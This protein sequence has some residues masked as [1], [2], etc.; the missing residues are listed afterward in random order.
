MF[1]TLVKVRAYDRDL[2]NVIFEADV[3]VYGRPLVPFVLDLLQASPR[4]PVVLRSHVSEYGVNVRVIHVFDRMKLTHVREMREAAFDPVD[5]SLLMLA[6]PDPLPTFHVVVNR[7]T[8]LL[9]WTAL[10]DIG[11]YEVVVGTAPGL[12][13]VGTF[14]T[15]AIPQALFHD[16]PAGTFYVRVRAMNELG[17]VESAERPVYVPQ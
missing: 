14:R 1:S 12:N 4:S 13:D 9:A 5:S 6:S 10:P 3:D 16:V 2:L 15:G 7:R 8:A 11:E 17:S